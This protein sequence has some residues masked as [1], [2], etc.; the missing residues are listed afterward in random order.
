MSITVRP[1]SAEDHLAFTLERGSASFL[2]TPAWGKVKNQWRAESLGWF[3][4]NQLIGAGLVL[5][6]Q[7]PKLRRYLAYLPEGPVL[8]WARG[9]VDQQLEGA[10]GWDGDGEVVDEFH[11]VSSSRVCGVRG[12]DWCG[13][14]SGQ[15]CEGLDVEATV[16]TDGD[17]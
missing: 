11:E 16:V 2:Q 3:D 12:G 15:G 4:G 5:Y 6:R 1:I 9:D 10:V 17:A 13:V 7:L 14:G 8:D